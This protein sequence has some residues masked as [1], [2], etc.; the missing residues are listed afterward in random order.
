[1]RAD[2]RSHATAWA[3]A[4]A[5]LERTSGLKISLPVRK[6]AT[7]DD[8]RAAARLLATHRSRAPRKLSALDRLIVDYLREIPDIGPAAIWADLKRLAEDGGNAVVVELDQDAD[9]LSWLPSA[10]RAIRDICFGAFRKKV[11]RLR[12]RHHR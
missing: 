3:D 6:E 9:V 5:Q 7:P 12:L 10:G 1:M 4:I 8:V 11:Q 2:T